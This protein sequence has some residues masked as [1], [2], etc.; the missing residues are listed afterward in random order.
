[1]G[2]L[3][4]IS[5]E[6]PERR[7]SGMSPYMFLAV[8]IL[9]TILRVFPFSC[10]PGLI[11][12]GNPGRNSP[13]LLTC[14]YHL[15]VE[16]VR[17]ALKEMDAH[18][19]VANSKGIN[20]WCAATGGLFSNHDVISALKTSG[21]EESVD[22]RD[23]ILPQ[24][25]ATG[26]ES[27]AIQKKTGWKII[28]GPVYAKDLPAFI[29]NK[30]NKTSKMRDVRFPLTQRFEMAV[31]WA[32]PISVVLGIIMIPFWREAILP[33]MY[34]VWGLS[35]LLFTSFPLYGKLLSPEGKRFGFVFFDFGRGGFQLILWGLL[36]IGLAI[37][38]I[39]VG[40]LRW[41]FMLRWGFI[42]LI[43]VLL[44]SIDL[45]GS[46]PIFKSG[47]HSDRLLKVVLDEKKCKGAGLCEQVCPKNC[48]VV[49]RDRDMAAIPGA[50][51]C[52]QCGACIVQCPFDALYFRSPQGEVITPEAVRKY[53]LNLLGKRMKNTDG[54]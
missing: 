4:G 46:T 6:K 24:L 21:I 17:R 22:H 3:L 30:C 27:K 7:G 9:E 38:S 33:L 10:K 47:L 51:R 2:E 53:K 8:N 48:Y 44:L 31:A 28:W 14:N 11:R 13:V 19:L 16:R 54:E 1:M 49:D 29:K 52:V 37:Y 12:I 23:V 40:D 50:G 15:T 32:F 26:V 45:M 43:V 20:V 36:V 34:L 5:G 25:A 39:A 35:L 41:G 18:L 42:T